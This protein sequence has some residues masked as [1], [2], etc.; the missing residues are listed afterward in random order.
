MNKSLVTNL[1]SISIIV[2]GYYVPV[3]RE[4]VQSV[5][6]YALSG[7]VTNWVAI[8]MLFEKVPFCYGSGVIP[9]RFEE[10]KAG[11]K[12][13]IMN[14]FFTDENVDKFFK[15]QKDS[16][17]AR[18]NFKPVID[19]IDYDTMFEQMVDSLLDNALGRI[20]GRVKADKAFEPMRLPFKQKMETLLLDMTHSGRFLKALEDNVLPSHVSRE[21]NAKI[22][23]IVNERLEQLTPALVKDI[24]QRMI[25]EHLGWLVVWGGVLGGSI[26]MIMSFIT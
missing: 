14:E 3:Y 13:L 24:I 10:F 18:I 4:Q 25:R 11:I 1:G 23:S 6:F 19:A 7:A 22:E 20:L 2:A 17:A 5:G 21:V 9:A 8:Y 16:V 12:D 26:G 15:G